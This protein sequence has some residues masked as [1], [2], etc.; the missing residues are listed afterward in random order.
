MNIRK[1]DLSAYWSVSRALV[2]ANGCCAN[3][4]AK[5]LTTETKVIIMHFRRTVYASRTRTICYYSA[6]YINMF[7]SLCFS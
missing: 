3:I 4:V 2:L 5:Y 6:I 1:L 7:Y